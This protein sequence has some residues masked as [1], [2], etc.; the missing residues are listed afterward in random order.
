MDL[1]RN[2]DSTTP[3][4]PTDRESLERDCTLEFVIASG[5]GGQHRNKTE[6]GVRLTHRP[7]GTVVM[8]TE[9]R[10]QHQNREVAYER[11]AERLTQMQQVRAPR[12]ATRLP[13]SAKVRGLEAKKRRA[14]IK[15]ARTR[16]DWSDE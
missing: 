11:I 3:V 12:K 6:S 5:P 9:R 7:S 4:Y 1:R 14:E 10:S 13:R 2:S 8:A 15:Q 16:R